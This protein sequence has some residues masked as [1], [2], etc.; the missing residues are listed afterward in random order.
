MG[1]EAL[2]C[3][4]QRHGSH[5]R[6]AA[7]ER[8]YT[9]KKKTEHGEIE[10]GN[11][12][13]RKKKELR[14][15][16]RQQMPGPG[17][18]VTQRMGLIPPPIPAAFPPFEVTSGLHSPLPSWAGCRGSLSLRYSEYI[19]GESGAGDESTRLLPLPPQAEITEGL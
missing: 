7:T 6:R 5:W 19:L 1:R 18:W 9:P 13:R 15:K 11:K 14:H 8:P 2:V 12:R 4:K 17:P 16:E 10:P 3:R